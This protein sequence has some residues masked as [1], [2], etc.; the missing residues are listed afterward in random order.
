MMILGISGC[1]ALLVT[2]LGV[3]DSIANFADSQY[4]QIMLYDLEISL[5]EGADEAYIDAF[6]E[7]MQQDLE[8][9]LFM[10]SESMD[11]FHGDTMKTV[12]V[13]VPEQEASFSDFIHLHTK[14]DEP[15]AFPGKGEAVLTHKLAE[16]LEVSVGDTVTLRDSDMHQLTVTIS[17]IAENFVYNYI[18][19]SEGTYVSGI[20]ERPEY[21][22]VLSRKA[23]DGEI[24]EIAAGVSEWDQVAQINVIEDMRQRLSNM[25]ESMNYIVLLIVLCAGILAFIVLYNLTNIN[26][27]ERIR[28]IATIKVLGFYSGETAQYVFRENMVLAAIG[29]IVGLFLGKW[30]HG[31]VMYHVDVDM[32]A[33]DVHITVISYVASLLLTFVFALL[34]DAVLYFKLK[35]I[36]MAESLKS[37]E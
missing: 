18:Y 22:L 2:G 20:G 26:I 7:A 31:Y 14:E 13:M 17:G 16:K 33:F 24:H 12:T 9:S 5:S 36:N 27:T 19:L 15:I 11:I 25:M 34:V 32:V 8:E 4:D 37:I 29:A 1:T 30:L 28:E 21:K 3:K 6:N 10:D 23:G 35:R